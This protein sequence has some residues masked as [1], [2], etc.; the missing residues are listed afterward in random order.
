MSP[1]VISGE[2]ADY[3]IMGRRPPIMTGAGGL[4]CP[5]IPVAEVRPLPLRMGSTLILIE[6]GRVF[7]MQVSGVIMNFLFWVVDWN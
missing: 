4:F 3:R 7:T 2:A 6:P 1:V 5:L